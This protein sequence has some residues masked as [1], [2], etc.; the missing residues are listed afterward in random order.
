MDAMTVA[1]ALALVAEHSR[2]AAMLD[3]LQERERLSMALADRDSYMAQRHYVGSL[4]V[5]RV[6]GPPMTWQAAYERRHDDLGHAHAAMRT[7]LLAHRQGDDELVERVLRAEVGS[8][9]EADEADEEMS[10]ADAT[11]GESTAAGEE[12]EEEDDMEEDVE[13][14]PV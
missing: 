6:P 10:E 4:Q 1:A 11:D 7:A 3:L 2:D 13:V 5:P 14:S 12:E 9:S 8:D